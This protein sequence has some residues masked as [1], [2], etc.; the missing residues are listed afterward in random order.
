IL[1]P[2]LLTIVIFLWVA[3][4]VGVYLLEPLERATRSVMVGA[5]DIRTL[6]DAGTTHDGM[7]SISGK[8]YRVSSSG[9]VEIG[10]KEYKRTADGHVIPARVYRYVSEGVG[11]YPMPA[12][13]K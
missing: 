9:T 4:S 6:D 1:L 7:V 11:K 5:A 3:H 8:S 10:D 13:A 2:P 12:D